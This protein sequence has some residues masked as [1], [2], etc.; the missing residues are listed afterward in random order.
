MSI[1]LTRYDTHFMMGV[2]R[3]IK[4]IPSFF[5]SNYYQQTMLFTTEYVDFEK[6][7]LNRVIAPFVAPTELGQPILSMGSKVKTF[8]PAYIKLLDPL[9]PEDVI[10]KLPGQLATLET[11]SMQQRYDRIMAEI[12]LQ[13]ERALAMRKEQMAMA[14]LLNGSITCISDGYPTTFV[15]FERDASHTVTL[16]PTTFWDNGVAADPLANIEAWNDLMFNSNFGSSVKRIIF[17]R[18]AWIA[19]RNDG[20]VAQERDLQIRNTVANIKGFESQTNYMQYRGE[21][22]GIELWTC[23]YQYQEM[24][25][26]VIVTK[27][28]MDPKEVL[29]LGSQI[30]GVQA[31]GAILDNDS[32]QAAQSFSK[33][34]SLPNPSATMMLTQTAPLMV[35]INPN[36][37][38]KARVVS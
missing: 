24:V 32:L 13:H 12:L 33:V 6:M 36:S 11:S 14:A 31:Y 7:V 27:D 37:T 5:L 22:D 8:K 17:G 4:E 35:P 18:Q 3:E 9:K 10:K 19:F 29:L 26:G 34:Y 15:D 21:L 30:E 2:K 1:N 38:L 20:K 28:M 23:N 16:G 25:N